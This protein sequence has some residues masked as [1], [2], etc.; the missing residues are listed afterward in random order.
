[1]NTATLSLIPGHMCKGWGRKGEYV[2]V[3]SMRQLGLVGK[4]KDLR[5]RRSGV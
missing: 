1:M 4:V 5:L 2:E 3:T